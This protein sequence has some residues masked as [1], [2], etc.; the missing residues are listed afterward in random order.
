[1]TRQPSTAGKACS[2]PRW[3][4]TRRKISSERIWLG[5][6]SKICLSQERKIFYLNQVLHIY[7]EFPSRQPGNLAGA[8]LASVSYQWSNVLKV[9]RS[10]VVAT[11][12]IGVL[13]T[14]ALAA[15]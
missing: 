11:A 4:T 9:A 2:R 13:M 10:G 7:I 6:C 15:D 1:M 3:S 5:T 8:F 14:A 12:V